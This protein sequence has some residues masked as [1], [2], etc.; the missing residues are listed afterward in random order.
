MGYKNMRLETDVKEKSVG[1]GFLPHFQRTAAEAAAAST[2]AILAATALTVAAQA[3]T[4]GITNPPAPRSI[5]VVG[6]AAGMV[7]NIVIT[8]T[9]YDGSDITETLAM[10][11]TT[12]VEG[13]KAFSA[14]TQ[15]ELPAYTHGGTDTVS[16]GFGNKLG[17]PY[18]LSINTVLAAY[19]NGVREATAAAVTVSA[20]NIEGNTILLN[21][22][23]N[24]T[25]VDAFLIV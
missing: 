14:V 18:K 4:V 22:A 5:Q 17:L 9:A 20:T 21:S 16:V 6:D 15:I 1:W 8:G 24:G 19:L 2:T 25:S 12:V 23:L 7:G 10:N 11:G 3:I 13:A